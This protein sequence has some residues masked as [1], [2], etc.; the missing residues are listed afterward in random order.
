MSAKD[1]VNAKRTTS[2]DRT[3][4]KTLLIMAVAVISFSAN[5]YAQQRQITCPLSPGFEVIKSQDVGNQR[6]GNSWTIAYNGRAVYVMS[7]NELNDIFGG[8]LSGHGGTPNFDCQAIFVGK[9]AFGFVMGWA[10]D[11][12]IGFGPMIGNGTLSGV[13]ILRYYAHD[14]TM[15]VSVVEGTQFLVNYGRLSDLYVRL[16]WNPNGDEN[17]WHASDNRQGS[18][19]CTQNNWPWSY[20][21]TVTTVPFH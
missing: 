7:E 17:W 5:A 9:Q 18:G 14:G 6:K 3:M 12:L 15:K 16:C 21:S 2:R 11:L 10:R 8:F 19:P 20:G 13:K 1:I 4:K